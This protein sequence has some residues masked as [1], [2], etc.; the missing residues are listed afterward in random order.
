MVKETACQ[1]EDM[2][3]TPGSGISPGEG[4]G[5]QLQYSCLESSMDGGPQWDTVQEVT[6]ESD[7][8]EHT[9]ISLTNDDLAINE[10]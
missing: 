10:K 6:K 5:N 4:N 8:T 7:M 1:A 3:L 9:H 2:S